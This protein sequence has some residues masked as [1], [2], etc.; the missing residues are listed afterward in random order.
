MLSSSKSYSSFIST[1]ALTNSPS[2]HYF[3]ICLCLYG[4]FFKSK[5]NL[6]SVSFRP[7]CDDGKSGFVTDLDSSARMQPHFIQIFISMF[8]RQKITHDSI[9][10]QDDEPRFRGNSHLGAPAGT[11]KRRR[12]CDAPKARDATAFSSS[13]LPSSSTFKTW[14]SSMKPSL[15]RFI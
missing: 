13:S 11:G 4:A 3:G 8:A 10:E 1:I 2:V 9:W 14:N 12:R 6:R 15:Y 7:C 5:D